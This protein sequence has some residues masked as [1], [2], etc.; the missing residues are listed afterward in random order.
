[1]AIGAAPLPSSIHS[2]LLVQDHIFSSR[3]HAVHPASPIVTLRFSSV[4]VCLYVCHSLGRPGNEQMA[5]AGTYGCFELAGLFACKRKQNDVSTCDSRGTALVTQA[6]YCESSPRIVGMARNQRQAR[7]RNKVRNCA[8][9]PCTVLCV[10]QARS[11][12]SQH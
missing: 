7:V 12:N 2:W 1:M 5:A 9:V 11:V 10:L 6:Q 8:G 4:F 3:A